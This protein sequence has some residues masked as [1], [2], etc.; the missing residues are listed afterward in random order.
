MFN[1]IVAII[2]IL[3]SSMWWFLYVPVGFL[4]FGRL[5]GE[6][7][8]HRY[9]AHGSFKTTKIKHFLISTLGIFNCFGSPV[10]WA[11]V[12][13]SHHIN[14]DK[15]LD[16]HSPHVISWWKVWLISWQKAE[17]QLKH[18]V[19]LLKDPI[20]IT[21]HKYYFLIIFTTFVLLS[22]IDWR[23]PVF[24]ICIPSCI[25]LFGSAFLVNVV[26]HKWG[27]RNFDT[28][29]KSKNNWLVNLSLIHISEP[30]R[31]L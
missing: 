18:Y 8:T 31:P 5:G 14:S 6:I 1:H 17:L 9:I 23:L 10:S 11:I 4:L 15:E 21:C 26:C 2:G 19:D 27:Y 24:L 7:G 20:H 25:T 13:R 28:S 22:M 12:H 16:P 30:T 29:D 3:Y